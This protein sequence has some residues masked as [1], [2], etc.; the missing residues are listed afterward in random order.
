MLP[1]VCPLGGTVRP[2]EGGLTLRLLCSIPLLQTNIEWDHYMDIGARLHP[3]SHLFALG[4]DFMVSVST[5]LLALALQALPK[6]PLLLRLCTLTL[7]AGLGES[8]DGFLP[9]GS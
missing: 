9:L 6:F 4:V 3:I 2:G 5:G 8:K 1:A 7:W